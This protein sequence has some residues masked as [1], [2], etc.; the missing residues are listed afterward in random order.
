MRHRYYPSRE[1]RVRIVGDE[2]VLLDLASEEIF[3]L[4]RSGTRIWQLL[5]EHHDPRTVLRR[6]GSETRI[7]ESVLRADLADLIVE[8]MDE[9]LLLQGE[10]DTELP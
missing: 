4:N 8:L 6:L 9:G 2:A 7:E 10:A 1:V 3:R 5:A